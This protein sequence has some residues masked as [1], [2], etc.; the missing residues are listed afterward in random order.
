M[1]A[2]RPAERVYNGMMELPI[3]AASYQPAT[4]T[5]TRAV[6]RAEVILL[7]TMAE[8]TTS[9]RGSVYIDRD[10]PASHVSNAVAELTVTAEDDAAQVIE[11]LL[12]AFSADHPC[13]C[14]HPG[15][16]ADAAGTKQALQSRGYEAQAQDVMLLEQYQPAAATNGA[17]QIIPARAAYAELR[18]LLHEQAAELLDT[19]A[20]ASTIE[21][22]SQ[23]MFDQFDE[24]RLEGFL[25]R[26]EREPA[27]LAAVLSL[28]NVGVIRLWFTAMAWRRRG[29][30]GALLDHL[31]D[32][33]A[34]AQFEQVL[35]TA[36]PQSI[37]QAILR[38]RGFRTVDRL[39]TYVLPSA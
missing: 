34:R 33:C 37:G 10:R 36:A 12:A 4:A 2:L 8:E 20:P 30:A 14:V 39:E 11:E 22:T 5:L 1:T 19:T 21:Q 24:P 31:L 38:K 15:E 3:S 17:V 9:T 35:I 23:A 7:R 16:V 32:H 25:G 27:G 6:R 26:V 29:V 13:R 18:R 28:G